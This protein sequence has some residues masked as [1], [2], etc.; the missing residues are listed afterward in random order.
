VKRVPETMNSREARAF[1]KG[2]L[3][4]LSSD[5]PQ[6]VFDMSK[7]KRIDS[8]GI[9][10]FVQCMRQVM[11][12][13]GDIRLAGVLPQTAVIFDLTRIGRLFEMYES[14]TAAAKSFSGFLPNV[15]ST[16]HPHHLHPS[17]TAAE[18]P[19]AD[20]KVEATDLAARL[21]NR[22]HSI[23]TGLQETSDFQFE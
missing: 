13:D 22:G 10:V 15:P 11:R 16:L 4:L 5:R 6:I 14:S 1:Y 8:V 18:S 9:A 20:S 21:V 12:H 17:V 23:A 7:T 19:A 3:T 2:I